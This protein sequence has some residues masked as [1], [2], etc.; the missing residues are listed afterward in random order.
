MKRAGIQ[1]SNL[2]DKLLTLMILCVV[3]V[4]YKIFDIPCVFDLLLNVP[5]P[6][7]G[8][9][10]AYINLMHLDFY[11]A[12][13]MHPMFWSVPLL[14]LYY[15]FDWKLF[16]IK[17]LDSMMLILIGA[18]FLINWIVKICGVVL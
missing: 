13:S 2:R 18:G 16:K 5:C 3:L 10:R 6:S 9:T 17:W 1:I 14:L 8:M 15:I 4:V 12:F 11:G 7:C